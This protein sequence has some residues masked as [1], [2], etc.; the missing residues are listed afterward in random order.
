[1]R[2]T[3]LVKSTQFRSMRRISQYAAMA[4]PFGASLFRRAL[5][6]SIAVFAMLPSRALASEYSVLSEDTIMLLV[7]G[8]A[9]NGLTVERAQRL[10]VP[11]IGTSSG[12]ATGDRLELLALL[13]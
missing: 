3:A 13:Q 9:D 4:K 10:N 1:M 12:P 7:T 8:D 5:F 11:Y 6:V 2:R